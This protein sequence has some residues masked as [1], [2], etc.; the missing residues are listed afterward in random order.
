MLPI[1]DNAIVLKPLLFK[2]SGKVGTCVGRKSSWVRTPLTEGYKDDNMDA[3]TALVQVD[4]EKAFL[5]STPSLA[6]ESILGEVSF[7]FP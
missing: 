4:W 3:P 2:V 7:R 6:N 5:N 1:A